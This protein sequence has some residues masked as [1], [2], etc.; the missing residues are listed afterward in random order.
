MMAFDRVG[1]RLLS[2]CNAIM[3]VPPMI[4][5]GVARIYA[6]RLGGVDRGQHLRDFRPSLQVQ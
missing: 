4:G 5:R 3:N 6:R 1:A 2:C